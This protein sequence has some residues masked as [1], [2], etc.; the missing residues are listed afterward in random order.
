MLNLLKKNPI[1]KESFS[2]CYKALQATWSKHPVHQKEFQQE[3]LKS[4]HQEE[5]TFVLGDE[6][7]FLQL[8]SRHPHYQ[9]LQPQI[10]LG[11]QPGTRRL[12]H[13]HFQLQP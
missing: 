12:L 2:K 9:I 11:R 7:A 6:Q 13:H 10:A 5:I 1:T 3:F 4:F 8:I